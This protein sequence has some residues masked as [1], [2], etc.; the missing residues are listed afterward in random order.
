MMNFSLFKSLVVLTLFLSI[1]ALD[2]GDVAI[3]GYNNDQPDSLA[4]VTLSFIPANSKICF[5]TNQW[6]GNAFTTYKGILCFTVDGYG[7]PAGSIRSWSNKISTAPWSVENDFSLEDPS[8][9]LYVFGGS[10]SAPEHLWMVTG[11]SSTI[12]PTTLQESNC[13]T[14][15]TTAPQCGI[16]NGATAATRSELIG[17]IH[18]P[19]TWN[20]QNNVFPSMPSGYF[21]VH[22]GSSTNVCASE[23]KWPKTV[24]GETAKV[25]C[26]PGYSGFAARLCNNNNGQVS[27]GIVDNANCH[28]ASC[29]SMTNVQSALSG[30][31]VARP[32]PAGFTGYITQT[33]SSGYNLM[34]DTASYA[35]CS[36]TLLSDSIVIIGYNSIAANKK[37]LFLATTT[38]P[39]DVTFYIT[40]LGWRDN[41]EFHVLGQVMQYVV[42]RGGIVAGTTF[43]WDGTYTNGFSMTYGTSFDFNSNNEQI[44]IYTG[45]LETPTFIFGLHFGPNG[46]LTTGKVT[47]RGESYLPTSLGTKGINLYGSTFKNAK[48][49]GSTTSSIAQTLQS[50]R[51]AQN[52][53]GNDAGFTLVRADWT[54]SSGSCASVSDWPNTIHNQLVN[55][56]CPFGYTGS[57]SR[58]CVN[59]IWQDVVFN[60]NA[61]SNTLSI[62]SIAIVSLNTIGTKGFSFAALRT[63]VPGEQI[64]FTTTEWSYGSQSFYSLK[65]ALVYTAPS[66]GLSAGTSVS[67]TGEN[68]GTLWKILGTFTIPSTKGR[69]FI[70]SGSET[71]PKLVYSVIYGG[72]N[73]GQYIPENTQPLPTDVYNGNDFVEFATAINF[74]Y[75]APASGTPSALINNFHDPL[76]YET[77]T[78]T[79]ITLFTDSFTISNEGNVC[80]ASGLWVETPVGS[81]ASIPCVQAYSGYQTRQCTQGSNAGTWGSVNKASCVPRFQPGDIAIVGFN[82]DNPDSIALL[83]MT[84]MPSGTRIYLT[85]KGWR[86]SG[87]FYAG[88]G[89]AYYDL[90]EDKYPG[91]VLIYYQAEIDTAAGWQQTGDFAINTTADSIIVFLGNAQ[92]STVDDALLM[93]A[94]N[95]AKNTWDADAINSSTCAEPTVLTAVNAAR[96][97][98]HH[99]DWKYKGPKRGTKKELLLQLMNMT[100]WDW[101]ESGLYDFTDLA[102]FVVDSEASGVYCESV[103]DWPRTTAGQTG[104]TTCDLG[105]SGHKSRVCSS[106]GQWSVT[107]D[108]SKC[109]PIYCEASGNYVKTQAGRSATASCPIGLNGIATMTCSYNGVW[110]E[111]DYSAC[112]RE[113]PV[114]AVAVTH[115]CSGNP[116]IIVLVALTTIPVGTELFITDVAFNPDT[117]KLLTNENLISYTVVGEPIYAGGLIQYKAGASSDLWD[118]VHWKRYRG[119]VDF[120]LATA[121]D[122]IFVYLGSDSYPFFLYGL[123]FFEAPTWIASGAVDGYISGLPDDLKYNNELAAPF[124]GHYYN[125]IYKGPVTG[126]RYEILTNIKN[127]TNWQRT[128]TYIPTP[129]SSLF[130]VTDAGVSTKCPSLGAWKSATPG[131]IQTAACPQGFTGNMT[132]VCLLNGAWGDIS[133]ND[134]HLIESAD[135]ISLGDVVPIQFN[136]VNTF[137][138]NTLQLSLLLLRSLP[139]GIEIKVTD[140]GLSVAMSIWTKTEGILSYTVPEGGLTAGTI[141]SYP[142]NEHPERWAEISLPSRFYLE[143]SSDQLY[144]YMGTESSS[145]M[146]YGIRY[147]KDVTWSG[148]ATDDAEGIPSVFANNEK[149]ALTLPSGNN[150]RWKGMAKGS[151]NDIINSL[152]T[153]EN[154]ENQV[155]IYNS[156]PYSSIEITT[157]N[158]NDNNNN[159]NA[160]SNTVIIVVTAVV[161]IL[162]IFVIYFA[163]R[164]H[165]SRKRKNQSGMKKLD[166]KSKSKT[167]L[168]KERTVRV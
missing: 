63:I 77:S 71:S 10:I 158:N 139:Q 29:P 52:W 143:S 21:T 119:G 85:D 163:F 56:I 74:K 96:S 114:G 159:G 84:F 168:A 153:V 126:T 15:Q 68:D 12:I 166:T 152:A 51:S 33:C 11:S 16:Y 30:Q 13:Y 142:D 38:I 105:Y 66:T 140:N 94:I 150:W 135:P 160:V 131:Q 136:N 144:V 78:T 3:V 130:T 76:K 149:T 81:V 32:C 141:I 164:I 129:F 44:F 104:Y 157:T 23:E 167:N 14:L 45:S 147:G 111:P 60:C 97:I 64:M 137:D 113:L 9:G 55:R 138:T 148:S 35:S 40:N 107:P 6:N 67:W 42:P 115:F 162:L 4:F 79:A 154:W 53:Q 98:D 87:T 86:P 48:Y 109:S 37:I 59:G 117:K 69:L 128:N 127:I 151:R 54:T 58:S 75:A 65:N 92:S 103:D 25:V 123:A 121:G 57:Q 165:V 91:D 7:L 161:V 41:N 5:T 8:V 102:P 80:A 101:K 89:Y 134:C 156:L 27:W 112:T 155:D 88:E 39:E 34:W 70:V 17:N 145:L 47:V 93:Y 26:E 19:S 83:F 31:T 62:G 20:I 106:S 124:M 108:I 49:N 18:N 132:R 146:M 72:E 50:I 43:V 110:G 61:M 24:A 46:W 116:D 22:I 28:R 99:D 120:G 1:Q 133:D 100:N 2:A 73:Y 82:S 90:T 36:S 95:Y 118:D 125:G 122:N